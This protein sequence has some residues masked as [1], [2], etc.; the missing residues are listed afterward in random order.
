[1]AKRKPNVTKS[2]IDAA[3]ASYFA[4]IEIHNKPRISYRYPSATL[5]LIDSW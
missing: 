4:A 5:L 2:L 3:V 1:M